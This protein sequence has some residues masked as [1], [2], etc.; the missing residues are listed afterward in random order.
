MA[1][2]LPA[3]IFFDGSAAALI[4]YRSQMLDLLRW[5]FRCILQIEGLMSGG[6]TTFF[7]TMPRSEKKKLEP[8]ASA[9]HAHVNETS[10]AEASAT[11]PT[12]GMRHA[13]TCHGR[14][15]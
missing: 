3:S 7:E 1:K 5:S 6:A 9:K 10:E 15:P 8:I 11:P 2:E 14:M 4:A 12:T 13:F